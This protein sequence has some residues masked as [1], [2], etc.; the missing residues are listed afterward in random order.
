MHN[1]MKLY[2]NFADVS[3]EVKLL[4]GDYHTAHKILNELEVPITNLEGD[5]LPLSDRIAWLRCWVIFVKERTARDQELFMT[6]KVRPE[7]FI[8]RKF[9][10]KE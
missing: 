4:I 10:A 3:A 2:H 9:D 6:M 5:P 8:P 1:L 7:N